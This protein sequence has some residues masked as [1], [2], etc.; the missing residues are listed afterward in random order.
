MTYSYT[1]SFTRTDAKHV[2]SKVAADLGYMRAL[3]GQ[4]SYANI[5]DYE[6]EVVELLAG[7]Y[8]DSVSYGLRRGGA[9]VVALKYVADTSGN[10]SGD[11]P[12]GALDRSADVTGAS[13]YSFLVTNTAWSNLTPAERQSIE[14][15]I[16][17]KRGIGSE[18][19]VEGGY[20][21]EDKTYS[22]SGGGVRR[23]ATRRFTA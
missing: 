15:R 18:P 14:D 20:W 23:S 21:A 19:S 8:L 13:F 11:D 9:Y 1:R 3:Y 2:A 7:G 12:I 17:V 5:A 10:L 16:P 4:P 6:T 22:S